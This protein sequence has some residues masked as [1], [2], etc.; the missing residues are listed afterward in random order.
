MNFTQLK[1]AIDNRVCEIVLARPQK[2]NALNDTLINELTDAFGQA[3][4]SQNVKVVVLTGSGTTFCAGADLEYLQ[5]VLAFSLSENQD[6]SRR[7]MKLYQLIF[8]L[9][10]PVIA[11]VNGPA[12]AGGCGL[13]T[14]CD[15]V[16]ASREHALFGYPEVKIGFIPA[17]V[18]VFLTRRIGEGKAR[19]LVLSGKTIDASKALEMGLATEV[20]SHDELDSHTR[21][22]ADELASGN[23]ASSM[24]L[25]KEM[26]TSIHGMDFMQAL[27]Y[28]ANMNAATRMTDDCKKGIAA[29]LKKEKIT[30]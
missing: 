2:R 24:A 14:V 19:E 30:W 8:E 5:K 11:K 7:L 10:K 18:L 6:D 17:L 20:V 28:A 4:K 23:S 29:F 27:E 15:F 16:L 26:L 3:N 1:Y 13:A 25:T 21:R 9:R 22:L 12:L